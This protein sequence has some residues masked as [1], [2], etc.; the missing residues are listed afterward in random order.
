MISVGAS[1]NYY[2]S[3]GASTKQYPSV[4][5]DLSQ[6]IEQLIRYK[7]DYTIKYSEDNTTYIFLTGGSKIVFTG[8]N[9]KGIE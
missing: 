6:W 7:V 4:Y 3:A 1:S 8:S 2:P 5:T 9:F